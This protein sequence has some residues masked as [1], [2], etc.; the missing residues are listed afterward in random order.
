MRRHLPLVVPAAFAVAA[1]TCNGPA[2][3]QCPE[4]GAVITCNASCCP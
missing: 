4:S 2:I 3:Q 1:T